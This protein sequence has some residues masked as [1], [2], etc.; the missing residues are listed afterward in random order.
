M[1]IFN[2]DHFLV[3]CITINTIS[4]ILGTFLWGYLAHKFGNITTVSIVVSL[5]LVGGIIGFFSKNHIIII[6]FIIFFGIGD[7]GMETIAGPALVEIF[8][9]RTATLL[10]PYKG[11]SLII[12]FLLAPVFQLITSTYFNSFQ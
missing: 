5:T 3:V 7:R 1:P 8:G 11:L 9:L 12:G 2:D 6:I 4:N 10:L